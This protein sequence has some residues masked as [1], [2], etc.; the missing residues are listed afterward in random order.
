MDCGTQRIFEEQAYRYV[1]RTQANATPEM[2]AAVLYLL[3]MK[4][5]FETI[6]VVNQDYAWG[7]DSWHIFSTALKRLKP[8]VRVVAELFPRFGSPD[9]ST[10]ISRLLAVRPDVI[11]STAWAAISTTSSGSRC[12][13]A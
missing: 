2:L 11:L 7:R 12:S 8:E 3:K 6:A 5:E 10:E 13:A 4:P 1:F 9:F